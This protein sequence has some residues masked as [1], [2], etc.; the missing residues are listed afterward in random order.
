MAPRFSGTASANVAR[1]QLGIAPAQPK[2]TPVQPTV[3]AGTVGFYIILGHQIQADQ[4]VVN[5]FDVMKLTQAEFDLLAK[6]VPPDQ[7]QKAIAD[8]RAT[9]LYQVQPQS[10]TPPTPQ[11]QSPSSPQK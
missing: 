3:T 2:I 6:F 7:I 8:S 4:L 10:T 5:G 11:P 9:T 1:P